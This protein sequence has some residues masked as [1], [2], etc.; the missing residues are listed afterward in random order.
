ME[1]HLFSTAAAEEKVYLTQVTGHVRVDLPH[2]TSIPICRDQSRL[3]L[4]FSLPMRCRV[5]SKTKAGTLDINTKVVTPTKRFESAHT[6]NRRLGHLGEQCI[7]RLTKNNNNV[8][9]TPEISA[10]VTHVLRPK[11]CRVGPSR[12]IDYGDI[13]KPLQLL[14]PICWAQSAMHRM[15]V[16]HI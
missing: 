6:E 8:V 7:L 16:Q 11:K 9:S 10:R 15:G 13:T 1:Q 12:K 3:L 5:H 14:T 2:G 4:D